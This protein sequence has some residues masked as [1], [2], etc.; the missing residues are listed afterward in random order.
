MDYDQFLSTKDT[1]KELNVHPNT[2]RR[3][4]KQGK[5]QTIITDGGHRRY[6]VELF[7]KT[8]LSFSKNK[9]RI[10]IC[11]CRVSSPKQRDDLDRQIKQLSKQFPEFTIISDIGS[12]LNYKR[13][14]VKTILEYAMS[15][16]IGTVVV[17]YRDRLCRFGF[18]LIEDI[19]NSGGGK[20]MVLNKINNSP[21]DELVE[22]ITAIMYHFSAKLHGKR[23]YITTNEI[24]E[25]ECKEETSIMSRI[26]V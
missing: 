17:A 3:W 16:I 12:G 18:D 7:K 20:I 26:E 25:E 1:I 21:E 15:G 22:D 2:L 4:D 8:H 10:N 5:I 24:I 11:Y 13:K 9:E 19:I 14:G 6:N 23:R